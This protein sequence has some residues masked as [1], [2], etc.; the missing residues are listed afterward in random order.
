M[1]S[2]SGSDCTWMYRSWRPPGSGTWSS[3]SRGRSL[4]IQIATDALWI[5]MFDDLP[6]RNLVSAILETHAKDIEWRL[7]ILVTT[8][9]RYL[10][11]MEPEK[12]ADKVVLA[13]L[14][15]NLGIQVLSHVEKVL[16][17]SGMLHAT[18]TFIFH[19]KTV[20]TWS[21]VLLM[22]LSGRKFKW[23]TWQVFQTRVLCAWTNCWTAAQWISH[24]MTTSW[25]LCLTWYCRPE[26]KPVFPST[27]MWNANTPSFQTELAS[28]ACISH[29]TTREI[30]RSENWTPVYPNEL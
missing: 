4:E 19:K 2:A 29:C 14:K 3:W 23:R 26:T 20:E 22:L 24:T 16:D 10:N 27:P 6:Y 18:E 21:F 13:Q 1:D 12:S 25:T 17:N 8:P 7:M 30:A 28:R 5:T 15:S 9:P 11:A